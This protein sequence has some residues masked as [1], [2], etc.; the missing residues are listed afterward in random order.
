[1]DL[2]CE[3]VNLRKDKSFQDYLWNTLFKF[4]L[5]VSEKH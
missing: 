2:Y 5:S 4:V 1:M 3:L